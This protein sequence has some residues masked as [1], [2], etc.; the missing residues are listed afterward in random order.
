M[1]TGVG[2]RG[3]TL[4]AALIALAFAPANAGAATQLGETFTGLNNFCDPTFTNVQSGSQGASYTAPFAGVITSWSHQADATPAPVK[5]KVARPAGGNAFTIVGESALTTPAAN[6]L[7][8]ALI[9]VPVDAGDMIGILSGPP[10]NADCGGPG[11]PGYSVFYRVGDTAPGTTN[12]FSGPATFR[13]DVAAAL[14]PDCDRDGFGDESQDPDIDSCPPGPTTTISQRPADKVK[15]KKKRVKATFTFSADD[16]GA[17]FECALDGEQQFK[18]CLSPLTVAV[19]R[20]THSLSITAIDVGGNAGPPA[21]DD[22]KVKR[23]K[24]RH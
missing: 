13:L 5:F 14:E 20:G 7:L 6:Q 22:W 3:F 11:P 9:R 1:V 15:T 4:T 18:S 21:G 12:P 10:T 16:P 17:T 8:T 19:R 2:F 23:K 24:K